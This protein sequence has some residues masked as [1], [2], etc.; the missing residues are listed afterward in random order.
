VVRLKKVLRDVEKEKSQKEKEEI[1]RQE[2]LVS[3][4]E[5]NRILSQQQQAKPPLP[6]LEKDKQ[7]ASE[8]HNASSIT[9]LEMSEE[10]WNYIKMQFLQIKEAK[11][12]I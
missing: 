7:P 4:E 8:P 6:P 3:L 12:A 11:T 10:N 1:K 9:H 5:K 2:Y